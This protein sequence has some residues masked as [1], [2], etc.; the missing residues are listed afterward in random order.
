MTTMTRYNGAV[1]TCEPLNLQVHGIHGDRMEEIS[2]FKRKDHLQN[3][4]RLCAT[5]LL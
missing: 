4:C 2:Y 1:Y 5:L 3:P